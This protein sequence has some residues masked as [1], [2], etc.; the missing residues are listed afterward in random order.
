MKARKTKCHPDPESFW[1]KENEKL[2]DIECKLWIL[3]KLHSIFSLLLIMQICPNSTSKKVYSFQNKS[4]KLLALLVLLTGFSE[5]NFA[6]KLN[7][8]DLKTELPKLQGSEKIIALQKIAR[9]YYDKFGDV[10]SALV[11]TIKAKDLAKTG[12]D[13]D[14]IAKSVILE[15]FGS[16][17]QNV[18]IINLEKL[19]KDES[20]IK[21]RNIIGEIRLSLA[22]SNYILGD[23][24]KA[25]SHSEAAA[26]IFKETS[27]FDKL[28]LTYSRIASIFT[29]QRLFD[30]CSVYQGLA[31]EML[32][33][34]EKSFTKISF[35]SSIL[36]Q[37]VQMG[38]YEPV[39]LDS[40]IKY[41]EKGLQLAVK[42]EYY[43]KGFQL[44]NTLSTAYRL[45]GNMDKSLEYLLFAK[46][47]S[48]YL[49]AEEEIVLYFGLTDYHFD[50]KNY[51][52][53][54]SYLDTV[55]TLLVSAEDDAYNMAY[56]Q[57][58]YE[59]NKELN[60]YQAALEGLEQ[61]KKEEDSIFNIENNAVILELN[62]KY[63]SD[64]KNAEINNL[65]QQKKIDG[66]EIEKNEAQ[67]K[68]LIGLILIA[69]LTIVIFI[70]FYRQRQTRNRLKLIETEQRLNLARINPHFF[71]NAMA[72]LQTFA[73]QEKSPQTSL[74]ISRFAKIMRQSLENTYDEMISI[75][76]E[77]DFLTDYLKIQQ[78]RFPDKFEFRFEIDPDLE[79]DELK[80]PGMLIQPFVENS[81]EHGFKNIDHLGELCLTFSKNKDHI[82]INITDNGSGIKENDVEQS[83]ISRAS[84]ITEDR[85]RLFNIQHSS[86]A[87][88]TTVLSEN[89]IGYEIVITLPQLY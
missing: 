27:N 46:Q 58:V 52:I 29:T 65:Q 35:Y 2:T 89:Q 48:P 11:Y 84:Q 72:S 21:D 51:S 41:G 70:V 15:E 40:A 30:K 56:Y 86:N 60:N 54:L 8:G 20:K 77:I 12:G 82:V 73:Y 22:F 13:F 67:I 75:E 38:F 62:E 39:Y 10:D 6:Q 9:L 34:V 63:Q 37:Y 87:S 49:R 68:W 83:H 69:L 18:S 85:L 64:L 3:E 7:I 55:S 79:I 50:A 57:R 23:F 78:L 17:N 25:F 5:N 24:D 4:I 81:I 33:K 80:V 36:G 16:S 19:L 32:P 74:F 76:T 66:L 14:A 53:C 61:F 47:F 42:D 28:V 59:Y 1:D 71:F 45:K 31:L 26:T 88:F 43:S 44:S